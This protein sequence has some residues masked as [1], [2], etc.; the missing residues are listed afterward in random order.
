MGAFV[1]AG[2]V[3][4][5]GVKLGHWTT[6]RTR[7][8][9]LDWYCDNRCRPTDDR[10]DHFRSDALRW[11]GCGLDVREFVR[12]GEELALTDRELADAAKESPHAGRLLLAV[13]A[14]TTG[15][16]T[17][18]IDLDSDEDAKN[19]RFGKLMQPVDAVWTHHRLLAAENCGTRVKFVTFWGH[20]GPSSGGL[21]PHVFSQWYEHEFV[22][23]GIS[24]AT[25]EHWMMAEKARL[26]GDDE[27]LAEILIAPSPGAA[28]AL[29]RQ[30]VGFENEMW[31]AHRLEIVT[32][33]STAKFGSDDAL[34]KYLVGT[35]TRVLVETSPVDPVW[36]IGLA[37]DDP[38]AAIPSQW[39]GLNL[40]GLA[41]MQARAALAR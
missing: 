23:A 16:W 10:L 20:T 32:R 14:L 1:T 17:T 21:G 38:A 12:D 13:E 35:G 40:L 22:V 19:T 30:V 27:R 2:A 15:A 5:R 25:A 33:G 8:W 24:Y 39:Q 3:D 34:R 31:D 26:F 11:S 36:G 6:N 41:L 7:D 29:G 4:G 9:F 18:P 37:V 28:K